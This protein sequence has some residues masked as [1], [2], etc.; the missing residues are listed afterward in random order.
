MNDTDGSEERARELIA[1]AHVLFNSERRASSQ[2]VIITTLLEILADGPLGVEQICREFNSVWP[3]VDA[4]AARIEVALEHS[5]QLDLVA[6]SENLIGTSWAISRSGQAEIKSTQSWYNEAWGRISE[7]LANRAR[8]DLGPITAAQVKLWTDVLIQALCVGVWEG[9]GALAGSLSQRPG[10]TYVYPV[11]LDGNSMLERVDRLATEE[12]TREFLKA[13]I[14]AALDEMD[15]FANELMSYIATAAVLHSIAAGQ[16]RAAVQQGI[17]TLEEVRA[18]IDTPLLINLLGRSTEATLVK[19]ALSQAVEAGLEVIAPEHVL[20]ELESVIEKVE[21]QELSALRAGLAS[22]VRPEVYR[23]LVE[24]QALRLFIDASEQGRYEGW[25]EFRQAADSIVDELKAIG[26]VVRPHGNHGQDTVALCKAGIETELARRSKPRRQRA[27]ERDADTMAMVWRARRHKRQAPGSEWPGGWIVSWDSILNAAFS[28][29]DPDDPDD[30]CLTPAQFALLISEAAGTPTNR[31]LVRAAAS[32]ARHETMISIAMRY[33]PETA[34]TLAKQLSQDGASAT[35]SRVAQLKLTEILELELDDDEPGGHKLAGVVSAKRTT[36]IA[37][38]AGVY[39]DRLAEDNRLAR[40]DAKRAR[41]ELEYETEAKKSLE[42]ALVAQGKE[43]GDISEEMAIA[44]RL[45]S[46]KE[47]SGIAFGAMIAVGLAL[48]LLS[49]FWAGVGTLA[50]AFWFY[51]MSRA[52]VT[53]PQARF[54][55]LMMSFL[56]E[57][58]ALVDVFQGFQS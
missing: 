8:D 28:R 57:S 31:Q 49:F 30:I 2:E 4:N 46:R 6:K 29:I 15:P 44:E 39:R 13:C 45:G 24:D 27:I 47:K 53:D 34:L 3:G 50:S 41:V 38:A 58:L 33:P 35:D 32:F 16:D 9:K 18:V 26:V 52:W 7:E 12:S 1:A 23:N 55:P 11:G 37:D 20:E 42:R 17:G 22:G 10:S 36:R 54:G 19:R 25:S 40:E 14:V 43:A 48:I 5:E 51:R 21:N 56:P